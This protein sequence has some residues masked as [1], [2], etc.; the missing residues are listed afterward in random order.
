MSYKIRLDKYNDAVEFS[1]IA[2]TISGRVVVKDNQG[3]CVN[4]KSILGM[5]YA[6][7]FESLEVESEENI[8]YAIRK[9]CVE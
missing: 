6:L 1:K 4:A 5:L 9:F 2:E 8:Y 7:E 3:H